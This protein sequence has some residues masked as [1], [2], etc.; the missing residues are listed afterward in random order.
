MTLRRNLLRAIAAATAIGLLPAA[1]AAYPDKPIRLVVPYAAGGGADVLG[2]FLGQKLSERLGVPVIVENK[3][4]ASTLIGGEFVAKAPADGYT[5]LMGTSSMALLP[6]RK[7]GTTVDMRKDLAPISAFAETPYV[8]LANVNAP[9]KTLPEMVAYAKANPGK[10]SYGVNGAGTSTHLV[11]E[12]FNSMAG[13]KMT[14]VPYKGSG[15]QT[16]GL[17]GGETLVSVDGIGATNPHIK[18]GKI[19]LLAT[20]GS[21]RSNIFPNAP[22]VSESIPGFVVNGWYGL[23]ATPGTPKE[24]I[25]KLQAAVAAIAAQ[26]DVRE[27]LAGLSLNAVSTTPAEYKRLIEADVDKWTKVVREANLVLE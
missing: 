25:D 12:Y 19:N 27:R 2:R 3:P 23:M 22:T 5:L 6:L 8:I 11:G 7:Q 15:P 10:L 1:W 16:I 26:P 24:A 20:T 13:I 14:A 4:G 18:E 9:F 17:L 21:A